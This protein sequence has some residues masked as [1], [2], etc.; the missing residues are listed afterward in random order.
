MTEIEVA[1]K[2]YAIPETKE[3]LS[4]FFGKPFGDTFVVYTTKN[5]YLQPIEVFNEKGAAIRYVDKFMTNCLNQAPHSK[6]GYL[7]V[8]ANSRE[9]VRNKG[10]D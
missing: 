8:D 10:H 7:V 4:P 2:D 6:P 5:D 3:Y 9:S 1:I